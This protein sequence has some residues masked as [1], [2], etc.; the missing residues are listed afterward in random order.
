MFKTTISK[1]SAWVCVGA[2]V[3]AGCGNNEDNNTSENN[4]TTNNTSMMTTDTTNNTT[5]VDMVAVTSISPSSGP[6]AGGT[7]ITIT[8]LGFDEGSTVTFGQAMAGSVTFVSDTSLQATTPASGVAMTVDVT[9]TNSDGETDT[10]AGAF[11][12]EAPMAMANCQIQNAATL[13]T[14]V[15]SAPQELIAVALDDPSVTPGEG[16]PMD[17][18]VEVE[19]GYGMDGDFENFTYSP[20]AWARSLDRVTSM[21]FLVDEYEGSFIIE[22]PGMFQYAARYR[23]DSGAWTYCDRD[24][25]SNGV[26]AGQL[27]LVNVAAPDIS[28]CK[29]ETANVDARPGVESSEI[30]AV[31]FAEG[32]TTR[33]EPATGVEME[34]VYGATNL[35]PETQWMD[36]AMA[37]YKE[38]ADN[39]FGQTNNERWAATLT[40]PSEQIVGY[41]FRVRISGGDWTYCDTNDDDG[42]QPADFG[43]VNVTQFNFPDSCRIQFPE[44]KF[45]AEAGQPVTISGK[46][47][48]GGITSATTATPDSNILAELWVGPADKDPTVDPNDFT[49][50]QGTYNAGG[51]SS[52][53]EDEYQADFTPPMAGV[54]KYFWRF[55]VNNGT[56]WLFCDLNGASM[57]SEFNADFGG[58]IVAYDT[59]PDFV[60]FCQITNGPIIEKF[61]N[62]PEDPDVLLDVYDQAITEGDTSASRTNELVV[63][64]GLARSVEANP[65]FPGAY[66]WRAMAFSEYMS[67][68]YKYR[69]VPYDPVMAPA[70]GA[71]GLVARVRKSNAGA[72]DWLYCDAFAGA[73]GM[74]QFFFSENRQAVLS[75]KAQ[76]N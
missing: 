24:G 74:N 5:V 61:L 66:D 39:G 28:F 31:F 50:V 72:D 35:D 68:N 33:P 73:A 16:P 44:L 2:L 23:V 45:D 55:S 43:S 46:V 9:V 49:I 13:D 70:E 37:T 76:P 71:Y 59:V 27:G 11:T 19:I 52:G 15:G 47:S 56:D 32:I 54:Y 64:V 60:D 29:V 58:G 22:T 1:A 48:E 21:D 75:V 3:L 42:F 7:T 14:V 4:D 17:A 30:T 12:Y 26:A 36:T 20:I 62:Q 34:I 18:T 69:A 65:A 8:G 63:E 25:S 57:A 6:L 38:K 41:V 53:I 51:S 40:L 10:L 67:N